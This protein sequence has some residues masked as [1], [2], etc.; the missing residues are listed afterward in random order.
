[1]AVSYKKILHR[2]IEENISNRDL[3]KTAIFP[4]IIM[5][6]NDIPEFVA[7]DEK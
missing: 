4:P 2:M 1:M 7:E 3:M 6:L 5:K